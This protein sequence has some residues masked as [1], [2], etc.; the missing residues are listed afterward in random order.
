MTKAG[1][2][3]LAGQ[4]VAVLLCVLARVPDRVLDAWPLRGWV[5][6]LVVVI[7]VV[8]GARLLGRAPFSAWRAKGSRGG[9]IRGELRELALT[10]LVGSALTVPIYALL[11]TGEMWW[12]AAWLLF[13]A[14]T[15]AVQAAM[16]FVM[17]LVLGGTTPAPRPLAAQVGGVGAAA[18]VDVE[19]VLVAAKPGRRCNAYIL[20]IGRARRVVLDGAVA[21]WPAPMVGQVVAHEMG[22]VRL[23]HVLRR[24]A[25][26]VAAE[27]MTFVLAGWAVAQPG[28]FHRWTGVAGAGDPRSYP[29]LLI[30]TPL[31]V[32]PAR[33]VMAW[34][35]RRQERQADRFALDLLRA[36]DDFVTML[37]RAAA[38]SGAPRTLSWPRHIVASH[39]PIAER[40]MVASRSSPVA[41][42]P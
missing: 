21:E 16:P 40:M 36:P 20:G 2:G 1:E 31:V 13:A 25:M 14:V 42:Q 17:P 39:P 29:L 35:D 9:W 5:I 15:L 30:L 22:H 12:L 33:A 8:N 26:T 23:G 34:Y 4:A 7:A 6:Q 24:L 11:R 32:F 37:N 41:A 10:T 19:R 28:L 18:G 3:A 27:L 38:E